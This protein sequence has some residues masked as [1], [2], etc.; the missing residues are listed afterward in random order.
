MSQTTA[1]T[2][3]FAELVPGDR[4]SELP[5]GV[6]VTRGNFAQGAEHTVV[7]TIPYWDRPAVTTDLARLRGPGTAVVELLDVPPLLADDSLTI[8]LT[9]REWDALLGA[10][11][12][13]QSE[14]IPGYVNGQLL[15]DQLRSQLP[16]IRER[17]RIASAAADS[18]RPELDTSLLVEAVPELV[19]AI[20]EDLGADGSSPAYT[21]A[22]VISDDRGAGAFTVH[23]SSRGPD[24]HAVL[25]FNTPEVTLLDRFHYFAYTSAEIEKI[26][27]SLRPRTGVAGHWGCLSVSLPATIKPRGSRRAVG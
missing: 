10:S 27:D 5:A 22:Y 16:G 3:P 21:S 25:I 11:Y 4:F 23:G 13:K 20:R 6:E 12:V 17:E 18:M 9:V 7:S 26:L 14:K 24:G 19:R 15:K 8:T 2:V 1:H